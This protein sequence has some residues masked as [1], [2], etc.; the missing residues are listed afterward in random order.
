VAARILE[1]ESIG[2][3]AA[4]GGAGLA[5]AA[6][7]ILL[8]SNRL[9]GLGADQVT[10]MLLA[11]QWHMVGLT[12][13]KFGIDY[14]LFAIISRHRDKTFRLK[15][16]LAFPVLPCLA[17]FA[18]ASFALFPPLLVALL[19]IAV[20]ADTMSTFRQAELNARRAFV[21]SAIGTLLNYPLFLAVW[22]A[23]AQ[24]GETTLAEGFAAFALS[25]LARWGWFEVR[26]A[27]VARGMTPVALTVKGMIG[28]QGALNLLLFRSDQIAL[29]V[30]LFLGASALA[31]EPM[32]AAYLFLARVPEFATGVL[33]LAGTVYFP[34]RHLEP[35]P[36]GSAQAL[37]FY[38]GAAALAALG[39]AAAT[40]VMIPAF[41]GPA[42]TLAWCLP[43][44]AQIPL[45]L[46]ANLATYSMQSQ[47][48]LPALIRNLAIACA[49]GAAMVVAAA[50]TGS[51]IVLAWVVPVQLAIFFVLAR[52]ATWGR[53][54]ALFEEAHA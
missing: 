2:G 22:A 26:H 21:T 17:A 35:P 14:A 38:G 3:L 11:I 1:R 8:A 7:L 30:L 37:R 40:A 52:A 6:A 4:L 20:F 51:L 43:F 47:S 39:G 16:A 45:I 24:A 9:P 36:A 32:L 10:P 42:P 25:S 49:G 28:A 15:S 23:M 50:V 33:V 13:A 48:Y 54:I 12:L 44:V 5:S 31:R 19:A 34:L 41:A 29:A 53:P 18:L 27:R 46:L